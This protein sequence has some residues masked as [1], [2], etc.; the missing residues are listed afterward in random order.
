M[1]C[2]VQK[3]GG[4]L[5]QRTR[6]F[7][8][9]HKRIDSSLQSAIVYVDCRI[10]TELS[11]RYHSND[12]SFQYAKI[13]CTR[14]TYPTMDGDLVVRRHYYTA[15]C[16]RDTATSLTHTPWSTRLGPA[17]S[18]HRKS[19]ETMT[20]LNDESTVLPRFSAPSIL[21]RAH[22]RQSVGRLGYVQIPTRVPPRY[23]SILIVYRM[24]N[25]DDMTLGEHSDGNLNMPL[26]CRL[27]ME[28]PWQRIISASCHR[29]LVPNF[30]MDTREED[31]VHELAGQAQGMSEA[32]R[33]GLL[34][35]Q[36]YA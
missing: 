8:Q 13:R 12:L 31:A 10:A 25:E 6:T 14:S 27:W 1:R 7:F 4:L 24:L 21:V 26:L 11:I 17:R 2:V 33:R 34:I 23:H 22:D 30:K 19:D 9:Q 36:D 28:S 5:L 20:G 16:R 29:V 32:V 3:K 15:W 18:Q 35:L